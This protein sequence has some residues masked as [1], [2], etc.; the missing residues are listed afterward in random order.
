MESTVDCKHEIITG[1]DVFSGNVKESMHILRHLEKQINLGITMQSSALERGYDTGAVHRGLEFLW[2]VG[3]IPAIRFSN[4]PDKYGFRYLPE[5]DVFL[6]PEGE[7]L[8]YARLTCSRATG[9]YL[10]CYQ[11]PDDACM[12]CKKQSACFRNNGNRRWI[13]GNSCYPAF[14]RG[15]Q[16]VGTAE[17]WKMMRLRKIWAEGSFVTVGDTFDG[18]DF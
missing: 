6:C 13:L 2:V 8:V 7:K 14:Y 15:H 1:V 3:Y 12:L 16:R 11:I 4:L 17:Y 10:R 9:K 18:Y 5:E